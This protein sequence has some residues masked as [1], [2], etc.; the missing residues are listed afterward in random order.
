MPYLSN[1]SVLFIPAKSNSVSRP[2]VTKPL[3]RSNSCLIY[4]GYSCYRISLHTTPRRLFITVPELLK[5]K[6][7]KNSPSHQIQLHVPPLS[8]N[9]LQIPDPNLLK[10]IQQLRTLDTCSFIPHLPHLPLLS[11]QPLPRRIT[12]RFKTKSCTSKVRRGK[13]PTITTTG[14]RVLSD[15]SAGRPHGLELFA[16][17]AVERLRGAGCVVVF[18]SCVGEAGA[19]GFGVFVRRPGFVGGGLLVVLV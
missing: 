7:N 16:E 18:A 6:A 8:L 1:S 15:E 17:A 14:V 13:E 4:L 11:A 2:N 5:T 3:Y 19:E 10:E 9:L 12:P